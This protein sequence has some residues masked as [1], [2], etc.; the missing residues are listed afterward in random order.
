M[1]QIYPSTS[2]NQ[3]DELKFKNL[4]DVSIDVDVIYPRF[5]VH[6]IEEFQQGI[7][8]PNEH[9]YAI[10]SNIVTND[11]VNHS[12][13]LLWKY[14]ES[15]PK[16]YHIQRNT[17]ET[18]DEACYIR[19]PNQ[20]SSL[21]KLHPR[22]IKCKADD[23][24]VW[25]CR[26]IHCNTPAIVNKEENNQ[27]ELLRI[28]SYIC[29]SPLSMFVP[30]ID[31]YKNL[32]EFCQLR[33]QFVRDR[34]TYTHSPLEFDVVSQGLLHDEKSI[35][36]LNAFQHSLIIGTHIEPGNGTTEIDF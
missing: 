6:N 17:L 2:L 20:Y 25:V 24:I 10:F 23:F 9:G 18:L 36:K 32:E 12:V 13:N 7:E 19:V 31:Q 33:E 29:M 1:D 5:S 4:E 11:E 27:S 3:I 34:V 14:L 16:S 30:K 22:L 15:L 26:S 35:L 28:I 21:E 8:H